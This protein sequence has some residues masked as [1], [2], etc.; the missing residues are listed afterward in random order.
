MYLQTMPV[1]EYAIIFGANW[2]KTECN[3]S[4]QLVWLTGDAF[5]IALTSILLVMIFFSFS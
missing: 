3:P 1:C 5:F 2:F 4:R